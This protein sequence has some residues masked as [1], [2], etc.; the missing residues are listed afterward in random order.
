MTAAHSSPVTAACFTAGSAVNAPGANRAS[1]AVSAAR[2]N[3][4]ASPST[5]VRRAAR[6]AA[7]RSPRPSAALTKTWAGTASASVDSE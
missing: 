5:S 6:S 4:A 2:P 1:A 3:P 7:G